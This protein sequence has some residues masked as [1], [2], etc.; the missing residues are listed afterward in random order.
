MAG[1]NHSASGQRAL[2]R[3]FRAMIAG[4][5]RVVDG[6]FCYRGIGEYVGLGTATDASARHQP[7]AVAAANAAGSASGDPSQLKIEFV[8]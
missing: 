6:Y 3:Q 8:L 5:H 2:Q 7:I 4:N 1:P